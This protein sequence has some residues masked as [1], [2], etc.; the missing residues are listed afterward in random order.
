[1]PS[2]PVEILLGIYLGLLTGIFPALISGGLGFIFKYFTGVTLPGLGVVVLAVAVAGVNG[3]LLGLIDP[4]IKQSPRLLVA[5]T[6]VMM[7]ALYAHSQGDKLGASLPK[8]FSLRSLRRR[9]LSMDVVDFVGG[10]GQVT[11]VPA[12]QV[13]DM[14]G[15]PPLPADVR[16]AI[17]AG[18][19]KFP[20]DVPIEELERRLADRLRSE[21]DLADATATIDSHGRATI[22]AAP[23]SGGLSRRVPK[24]HRAVSVSALVPTG[25]ARG[26]KVRVLTDGGAV[27]GTV[28]SAK[29]DPD[30][31]P[32][33]PAVATDGGEEEPAGIPVPTAAP[34]TTG[35]E[36]RI[37]VAVPSERA[38]TLL[39][40]SRG[41]VVVL[42]RGTR[43]EYELV[44]LFR[45]N[46]KRIERLT[47]GDAGASGGSRLDPATFRADHGVAVLAVNRNESG[48]ADGGWAFSPAG[49][50]PLAPGDEVFVAGKPDAVERFREVVR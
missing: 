34:T 28:L 15:Y 26:E 43:R 1:M 32:P 13:G 7:L 44:S 37:T 8:R 25:V 21:Y 39:G 22:S 50:A 12:G 38:G 9:T 29:S 40:A 23:P 10:I 19:W 49:S 20:A 11:I 14:E 4:T 41:R 27:S 30:A 42:S 46:G 45:R 33:A 47:I 24:G 31:D 16:S 6:V 35:G 2:L 36:G 48:D 18:S 3:G 17:G 5:V